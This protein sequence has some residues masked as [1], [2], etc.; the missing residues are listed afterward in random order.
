MKVSAKVIILDSARFLIAK[1]NMILM[2]YNMFA[3][4]VKIKYVKIVMLNNIKVNV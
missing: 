2:Q 3:M 4:Y 1:E